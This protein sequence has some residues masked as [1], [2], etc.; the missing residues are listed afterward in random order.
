MSIYNSKVHYHKIYKEK[1]RVDNFAD[2]YIYNNIFPFSFV[3]I[4]FSPKPGLPAHMSY[5]IIL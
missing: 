3:E 2:K 1:I 4:P 5:S